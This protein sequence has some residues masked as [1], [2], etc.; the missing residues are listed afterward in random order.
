MMNPSCGPAPTT[1]DWKQ[2]NAIAGAAVA[3]DLL[4]D[5]AHEADLKLFGQEL[6]RTPF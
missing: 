2:P 4:V 3:T 1:C 5:I 6:R